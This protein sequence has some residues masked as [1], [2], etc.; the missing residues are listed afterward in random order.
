MQAPKIITFIAFILYSLITFYYGFTAFR[1]L[2]LYQE[3]RVENP[4]L[5]VWPLL[6]PALLAIISL[7][8]WFHLRNKEKKK[9][10]VK[11]AL[12]LSILLLLLPMILFYMISFLLIILPL[13]NLKSNF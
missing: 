3:F 10:M 12:P 1:M 9:E 8:F 6:I 5:K 13:Y 11:S 7:A 2:S 4:I